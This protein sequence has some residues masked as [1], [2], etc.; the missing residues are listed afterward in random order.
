MKLPT[1]SSSLRTPRPSRRGMTLIE[2]TVIILVLLSLI[3][4]LFVGAGAWKRGSDRA[5]CIM[6]IRTVQVAVRSHENLTGGMHGNQYE[7][8][9]GIFIFDPIDL[10]TSIFGEDGFVPRIPDCPANGEYFFTEYGTPAIGELALTCSLS[11]DEG[12][13]P[14]AYSNW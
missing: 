10:A 11:E 8:E 4:I 1:P 3:T 13:E 14:D 5:G 12:H 9:P 2:L 7:I 6:N